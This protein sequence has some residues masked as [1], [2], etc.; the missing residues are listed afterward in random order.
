MY[1]PPDRTVYLDA[2]RKFA[3]LAWYVNDL[4][5][6]TLVSEVYQEWIEDDPEYDGGTTLIFRAIDGVEHAVGEY[7][8]SNEM[9]HLTAIFT[10]EPNLKLFYERRLQNLRFRR[11]LL[12]AE[13]HSVERA[14]AYVSECLVEEQRKG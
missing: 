2:L 11:S 8:P 13:V 14:I 9:D 10:P 1:I 3:D 7:H 12:W 5:G 6:S 4:H